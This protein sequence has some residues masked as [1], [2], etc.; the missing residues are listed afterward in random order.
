MSAVVNLVGMQFG[1]LTVAHRDTTKSDNAVWLCSCSCQRSD[2]VSVSGANLRSGNTQSCGC[3][4]DES[5]KYGS[6]KHG[7]TVDGYRLPEYRVWQAMISRCTDESD[8]AYVHYGG[9]GIQVCDR[10]KEA[11]N[12]LIDMGMRPYDAAT[13]ERVDNNIGYSKD[14]CR[15]A[16][17]SEQALNRRKKGTCGV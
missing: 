15:W 6:V 3:M 11:A 10:W 1:R 7:A 14:N 5:R 4:R 2:L 16:T 8:P 17:S 12:F 9:R 13:L